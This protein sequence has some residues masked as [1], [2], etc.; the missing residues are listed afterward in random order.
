MCR[1]CHLFE[2]TAEHIILECKSLAA[3]RRTGFGVLQLGVDGDLEYTFYKMNELLSQQKLI[4]LVKG[5]GIR[6]YR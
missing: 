1:L 4:H 2:E 5:T 6:S 3:R